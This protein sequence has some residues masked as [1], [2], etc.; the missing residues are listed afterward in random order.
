MSSAGAAGLVLPRIS[1]DSYLSCRCYLDQPSPASWASL[2]VHGFVDSPVS[3]GREEHG[4]L[5]GGGN[6]YSL[7]LFQDHTYQLYLA[8]GA[9]DSCPP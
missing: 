6:F 7:L 1:T 3:W 9:N 4:V 8:A 2:T 5:K